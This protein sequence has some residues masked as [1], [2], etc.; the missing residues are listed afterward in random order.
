ME[1]ILLCIFFAVLLCYCVLTSEAKLNNYDPFSNDFF[2][3]WASKSNTAV[4]S[5]GL[6][7]ERKESVLRTQGYTPWLKKNC[8]H[9]QPERR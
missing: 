8:L 1:Q 7:R 6:K 9:F 4:R 5:T 3:L 2:I